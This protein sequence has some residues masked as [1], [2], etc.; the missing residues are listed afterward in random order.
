MSDTHVYLDLDIINND[1]Y[2]NDD[3]PVLRF[4]ETRNSPFLDGD[5]SEYYVSIIR[6]SIQTG[7]ELPIFIPRIETGLNQMNINKTVYSVSIEHGT[8]ISTVFLSWIPWNNAKPPTPPILKQDLSTR[9]YYMN[10]FTQFVEMVNNALLA[11]WAITGSTIRNAPFMDFDPQSSRFN[12]NGDISYFVNGTTKLYFNTRLFELLSSFPARFIQ[13]LGELNYRIEFNN[14]NNI[15]VKPIFTPAPSGQCN[16]VLYSALQIFQEV[17]T[18]S[19]FNPVASIVF[20]SSLLPIKA[21]NTSPPKSFNDNNTNLTGGGNN[22]NLT[23]I[24]TDFEIGVSEVNQY[25]PNINY[26]ASGVYR[27]IDLN[28]MLNLNRV[29]LRVFW[30]SQYGDLIDFHLQPGMSAHL[31]LLFRHKRFNE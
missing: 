24:L 7:N 13:N 30:K 6:F 12:I 10:N 26:V 2:S 18:I 14:N 25:R 8:H 23:S 15:N 27:L 31:K 28:S 3:P 22:A 9:Y 5:S 20:T 19:L 4:E 21:T 16:R 1:Q 29:D 11:A 17:S